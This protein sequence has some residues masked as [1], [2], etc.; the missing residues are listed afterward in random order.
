MSEPKARKAT[1][2]LGPRE[3]YWLQWI[4]VAVICA[5]LFVV[6]RP[7]LDHLVEV[8]DFQSCQTN[9]FKISKAIAMYSQEWDDALPQAGNWTDACLGYMDSTSGTG[10][11]VEKY[12]K[13]PRDKT[14]SPSSY[15]FNRA[16]EGLSLSVRSE[17]A[18]QEARRRRL[19]HVAQSPMVIERHGSG[20]N[21]H[22]FLWNW[23]DVKA[24]M[25][26]PH[27]LP[28]ATGSYV[29]AGGR[30]WRRTNDDLLQLSGKPF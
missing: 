5:M 9:T 8:R 16:V 24:Q 6:L 18:A 29:Q 14:S 2:R 30:P 20:K 1:L 15:V 3:R 26:L 21:E 22:L 28:D 27:S 11:Q 12:L 4:V 23:S 17:N 13:C 25:T 7:M 19:V 10:F